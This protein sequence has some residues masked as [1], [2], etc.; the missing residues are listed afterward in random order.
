MDEQA[1]NETAELARQLG[2][3]D[4]AERA[5]AAERLCLAGEAA[6]AAALPLV[7]GCGDT[8]ETVR[9]HAVAALEEL[10]P[11]P[12]ESLAGLTDLVSATDPLVAYW[13]VTLLGRLGESAAPAVT[14]LTNRLR[15]GGDA[16]VVQR[17]AWALGRIGPAA[18]AATEPLQQAAASPD[19]RLARLAQDALSAIGG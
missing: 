2:S 7:R 17:V 5:R 6:A 1:T 13:A 9:E 18:S 19:P 4:S 3:A 10:G 14:A 12:P 16:S 8:D 15:Q 11:P